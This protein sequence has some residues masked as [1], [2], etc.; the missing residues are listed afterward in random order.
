M[1]EIGTTAGFDERKRRW[2]DLQE[3]SAKNFL[4]HPLVHGSE[5]WQ[6]CDF[7]NLFGTHKLSLTAEMM[8]IKRSVDI[9]QS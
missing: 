1:Q 9:Y 7:R 8:I 4:A 2:K 6:S 5:Q 3:R